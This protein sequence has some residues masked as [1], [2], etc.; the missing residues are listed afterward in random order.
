MLR[1]MFFSTVFVAVLASGLVARP[2]AAAVPMEPLEDINGT[3]V[4]VGGGTTPADVRDDF[5]KR[6]G[7]ANAKLVVIPT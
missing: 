1:S 2:S 3:L 5:V 6:A 4:M 7:G